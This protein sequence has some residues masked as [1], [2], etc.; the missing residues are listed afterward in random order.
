MARHRDEARTKAVPAG[1]R[2]LRG[3]EE[4][5]GRSTLQLKLA[6]LARERDA[7]QCELRRSEERVQ[8]LE[9]A[10]AQARE[11]IAWALDA[12]QNLLAGQGLKL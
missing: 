8:Q 2:A 7:L 1:A 11:R 10:H 5:E 6:A 4:N 3:G 9:D 12:L